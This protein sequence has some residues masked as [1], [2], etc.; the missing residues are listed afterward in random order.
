MLGRE[1]AGEVDEVGGFEL[2][3]KKGSLMRND[4]GKNHT[5]VK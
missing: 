3:P 2:A 5:F 4:R 1:S